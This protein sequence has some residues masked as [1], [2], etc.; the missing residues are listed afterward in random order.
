MLIWKIIE[1]N[2]GI[3]RAGIWERVEHD[4]PAGYA[5]RIHAACE[6]PIAQPSAI[7]LTRARGFVLTNALKQMRNR[8]N[9]TSTNEGRNRR[10]TAARE[11]SYRGHVEAI[12]V[13]GSK[14]ADHMAVAEALRTVEKWLA[15]A[16]PD[17]PL[18]RSG[19]RGA[20]LSPPSRREYEAL[21][22]VAG[23]LRAR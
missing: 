17:R 7:G 13:D 11:P 10:Y 1:A 20:V 2:P 15:R 3:T 6:K 22:I 12:D 23:A 16:N 9:L 4:I 18:G 21:L 19:R 5:L 14:A 8:G